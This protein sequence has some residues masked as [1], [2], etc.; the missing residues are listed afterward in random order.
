MEVRLATVA[1]PGRTNEDYAFA[2]GDLVAVLDGVT[3]TDGIDSGCSHGP[4]WYVRRLATQ[5]CAAY[6]TTPSTELPQLLAT[7]IDAVRGD[8]G[9]RCDLTNPATPAATVC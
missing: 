7:A 6:T 5:L 4:A 8:H 1:A 9:N 3:E 2:I